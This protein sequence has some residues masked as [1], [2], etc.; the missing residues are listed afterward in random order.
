MLVNN[1]GTV[2]PFGAIETMP[3]A[4][5]DAAFALN[6]KGVM[7]CTKHAVPL[8]KRQGGAIIN[9]SSRAGLSG[10]PNQGAYSATKFA[11]NGITEAL[12]QELGPHGIRVN[13]LCPGA[14]ATEA[15]VAR[16]DERS[17]AAGLAYDEMLKRDF[18]DKTAL[19]RL[20][21]REDVCAAVV[22]L[23]SDRSSAITGTTLSVDA[24]CR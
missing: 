24:G 12:A 1:A 23:A 22:F 2:E 3:T 9:I 6:V 16:V 20:A 8:L 11:V 15:F 14:V 17:A 4:A 21:T 10:N 13:A 5:W 18:T 19:G 7:L